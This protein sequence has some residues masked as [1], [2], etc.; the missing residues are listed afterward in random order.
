MSNE[1][2]SQ[3]E[4]DALLHGVDSGA[5]GMGP[6]AAP[7]E[8]R[9]YD[10]KSAG[11]VVR[12]R[13]PGLDTV[14][15][16]FVRNFK[17]GLFNLLRRAPELTYRGT[18]VVR[19]DEYANSLP[20]PASVNR[21]QMGPLKGTALVV[22]EPRLVFTVVENFFGGTGRM[23][24]RFENRA[25]TPSE[26]RVIQLMLKQTFTDLAE[27]WTPLLAV[28]FEALP[29]DPNTQLAELM[30]GRDH[31][32]VSRFSVALD[33]GGGDFAIAMPYKML[34]PLREDLEASKRPRAEPDTSWA[35]AL[36]AGVQEA[37]LE[38]SLS[39]AHRQISLRDLSRLKVGDI[40]PIELARPVHLEVE[41]TPMFAGEFGTH[42]G[43]NAF[44]VT[45]VQ[46]PRMPSSNDSQE[47][48]AP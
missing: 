38:L 45:Q 43:F 46:F 41:R 9:I 30:D 10:F 44:K 25:F 5:V 34:E 32:V 27:A 13:L 7:G 12:G 21:V 2:L 47:L 28:T 26:Q 42:N 36:R 18:D 6:S 11:R 17:T 24:A 1:L 4:I 35:R 48:V 33:T 8:V 39:I 22:Y 29:H 15:E 31:M 3:D 20:V 14:N 40:I 16:R 37:D 19:F 23:P